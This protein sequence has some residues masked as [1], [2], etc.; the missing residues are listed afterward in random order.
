MAKFTCKLHNLA[1]PPTAKK[2]FNA[3]DATGARGAKEKYKKR[4]RL[5]CP[6]G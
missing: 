2:G 3:K 4:L 1:E 6:V 5:T